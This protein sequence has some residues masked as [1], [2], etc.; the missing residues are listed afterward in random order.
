MKYKKIVNMKIQLQGNILTLW[1]IENKYL[2][3]SEVQKKNVYW[4]ITQIYDFLKE[5]EL[6]YHE[7]FRD[8]LSK[9]DYTGWT[10]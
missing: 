4:P 5:N 2:W 6:I 10:I 7:V 8:P 3:C 9:S 1:K